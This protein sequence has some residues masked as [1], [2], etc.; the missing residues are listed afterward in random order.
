MIQT[1]GRRK[2]DWAALIF[3]I[4]RDANIQLFCC[5]SYFSIKNVTASFGILENYFSDGTIN[6]NR[7]NIWYVNQKLKEEQ[8]AAFIWTPVCNN[9]MKKNS[10]LRIDTVDHVILM[11][12]LHKIGLSDQALN[13]FSN[14]LSGGTQCVQAAGSSSS[15]LPV[16]KG[17]PQGSILGP[18][19]PSIH[20]LYALNPSVGS[21]GGWSLSQRSSGE[22]QGTP[23]KGHQSITGPHRDKRDK[24]PHTRSH[25]LLRTILKSPINLTCMFFDGGRKPQYPERTHERTH[26]YT[27]RTCKLHTERPQP[28]VEL[29]GDGANHHTAVQ[30]RAI[31]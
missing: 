3:L 4:R 10:K 15:L 2:G 24:Q 27:G 31:V 7:I 28:G 6:W 21:W 19:H 8:V 26:A 14:Y 1:D 12:R 23:W 30:T 13:W 16:L 11:N 17:V 22:R 29:W 9:E 18:F 20:F 25:S 5:T